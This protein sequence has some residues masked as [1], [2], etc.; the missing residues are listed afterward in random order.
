MHRAKFP[1]VRRFELFICH[2]TC[3]SPALLQ[4]MGDWSDA[5]ATPGVLV[6]A[7]GVP[8]LPCQERASKE[9]LASCCQVQ[10]FVSRE[11]QDEIHTILKR[12]N[13]SCGRF[14]AMNCRLAWSIILVAS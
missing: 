3:R 2:D 4:R 5:N 11:M 10:M 6:P 7:L 12:G 14:Y 9:V 1:S 8:A 13:L